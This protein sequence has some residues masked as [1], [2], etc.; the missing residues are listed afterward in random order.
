MMG[1]LDKTTASEWVDEET[2]AYDHHCP[3]KPGLNKIRSNRPAPSRPTSG[4]AGGKAPVVPKLEMPTRAGYYSLLEP[5]FNSRA[6]VA[7]LPPN[8]QRS[9]TSRSSHS[10]KPTPTSTP[11]VA[12]ATSQQQAAG[13]K[14]GMRPWSAG[15]S[16]EIAPRPPSSRPTSSY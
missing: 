10:R 7:K 16:F 8:S 3:H 15:V 13:R 6:G 1:L 9:L 5:I 2:A 12:S 14:G 4:R 11:R